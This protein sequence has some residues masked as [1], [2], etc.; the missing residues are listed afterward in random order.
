MGL[1]LSASVENFDKSAEKLS[2]DTEENAKQRYFLACEILE[3]YKP[4]INE[5]QYT[6]LDNIIKKANIFFDINDER[7]MY[8]PINESLID[9]LNK[10]N[11]YVK[12]QKVYDFK[13]E[14]WQSF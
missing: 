11:I 14:F 10:I 8:S 12:H 1:N 2:L 7:N 6:E 3:K 9:E 4:Y 5:E 13:N